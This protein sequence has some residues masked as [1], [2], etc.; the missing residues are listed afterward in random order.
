MT[1]Y[2]E[3]NALPPEAFLDT[4]RF[5]TEHD[6]DVPG[7]AGLQYRKGLEISLAAESV[8][9]ACNS[10]CTARM[11]GGGVMTSNE[12][13]GYHPNTADLLRGLLDGP[14]PVIVYRYGSDG[15]AGGG[16]EIKPRTASAGS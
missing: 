7:R 16:T 6:T 14:A 13:I 3:L 15:P 11:R 12:G 2:P 10:T 8:G 4:A 5:T 1:S 9:I